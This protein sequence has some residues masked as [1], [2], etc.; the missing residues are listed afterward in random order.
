MQC[1]LLI[2]AAR[3]SMSGYPTTQDLAAS[4]ASKLAYTADWAGLV[5]WG[6][7]MKPLFI[8]VALCFFAASVSA[9]PNL[10]GNYLLQGEDGTVRYTVRQHGCERV[11]IDRIDT[12]LGKESVVETKV[13]IVD[14]KPHGKTNTINHWVG[15]RLQIGPTAKHVYYGTDSSRNLHMSDGGSYPQC[16]G[17]CDEVAERTN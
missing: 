12:Y 8:S 15:N 6:G 2:N 7:H 5:N 17:P 10:S 3:F 11:E 16:D 4:P 1:Q 9:C 13:F 14:G